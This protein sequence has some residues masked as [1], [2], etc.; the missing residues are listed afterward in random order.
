MKNQ[1]YR[2]RTW[3]LRDQMIEHAENEVNNLDFPG[4]LESVCSCLA[5]VIRHISSHC[6]VMVSHTSLPLLVGRHSLLLI[7]SRRGAT[8]TRSAAVRFEAAQTGGSDWKC[9]HYS[10]EGCSDFLSS[11]HWFQHRF[12]LATSEP[13]WCSKSE[14]GISRN[15]R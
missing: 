10:E 4:A 8:A 9:F 3:L 5:G 13:T 12:W 15:N 14:S 7:S 6:D 11:L 2:R 1:Q